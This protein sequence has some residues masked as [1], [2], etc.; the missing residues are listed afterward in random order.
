MRQ[1]NIYSQVLVIIYLTV[2]TTMEYFSYR[3]SFESIYVGFPLI[4]SFIYWSDRMG[5][6]IDKPDGSLTKGERFNLDLFL[7]SF[8]FISGYLLSLL[9]QYNNSDTLGWWPIA[10]YFIAAFGI[11]FAFIFSITAMILNNHIKY[12]LF[13]SATLVITLMF[14]SF[15][16]YLNPVSFFAKNETFYIIFLVLIGIHLLICLVLKSIYRRFFN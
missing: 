16:T 6:V 8:T 12:T 1:F 10:I 9:F 4:A 15:M 14:I 11:L 7:I 2:L 13:Y 5:L 3:F